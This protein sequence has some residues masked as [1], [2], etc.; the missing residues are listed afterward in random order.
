[1]VVSF[2]FA[3]FFRVVGIFHSVFV[4]GLSAPYLLLCSAPAP[5]LAGINLTDKNT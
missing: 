1:M 3:V 2:C 5:E 4:S